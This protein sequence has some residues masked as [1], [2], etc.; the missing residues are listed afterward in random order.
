MPN[1]SQHARNVKG[2]IKQKYMVGWGMLKI[3]VIRKIYKSKTTTTNFLKVLDDDEE[4]ILP[5]L[6]GFVVLIDYDVFSHVAVSKKRIPMNVQ[7]DVA[8]NVERENPRDRGNGNDIQLNIDKCN[9]T[10]SKITFHFIKGKISL[11]PIETIFIIPS[12]LEYSK[13]KMK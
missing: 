8:P 13:G 3:N 4:T 12:E 9:N 2:Y 10:K 1:L 11:N 6:I 7:I 5:H